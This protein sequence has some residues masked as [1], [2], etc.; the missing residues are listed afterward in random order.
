[1]DFSFPITVGAEPHPVLELRNVLLEGRL[2]S[3]FAGIED[4]L[5]GGA[6]PVN[7]L[8]EIAN[9]FIWSGDPRCGGSQ[10]QGTT[11]L[12][13]VVNL[14]GIP[15]DIDLDGDGQECLYA[16]AGGADLD[17][18]CDGAG[19][20]TVCSTHDQR[21]VG[22]TVPETLPGVPSSCAGAPRMSDGYSLAFTFSAF[23]ARIVGTGD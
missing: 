12:D 17:V 23:P 2:A 16:A 7:E 6:V 13:L 15:P 9:P 11:L 3:G 14:L 8:Y 21:C 1:M 4:G 10:L 18:C 20:G 5:M 22:A 19:L